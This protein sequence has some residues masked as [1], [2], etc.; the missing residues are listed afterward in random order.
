MSGLQL[1]RVHQAWCN[2]LSSA[3]GLLHRS[4]LSG[5]Q[6][7]CGDELPSALLL[8]RSHF[9]H[10]RFSCLPAIKSLRPHI[11]RQMLP[12]YDAYMYIIMPLAGSWGKNMR[13]SKGNRGCLFQGCS[14]VVLA[15]RCVTVAFV[16]RCVTVAFVDRCV[17]VAFVDR[18][19]TVAF[20]ALSKKKKK[21]KNLLT[22]IISA[23]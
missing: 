17:T 9:C 8:G 21:Y 6:R 19:V 15:D 7:A 5:Y 3:P 16:D 12:G 20:V 14:T 22:G 23:L 10:Q 13:R 1:G 11:G 18:C 2:G 4:V